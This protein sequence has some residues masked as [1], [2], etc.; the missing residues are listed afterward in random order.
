LRLYVQ[1][2]DGGEAR[3]VSP[4]GM[5]PESFSVS[6]DG[7]FVAAQGPDSKI[8]IYPLDGGA[9]HPLPGAVAGESP[10]VWSADGG[11]LYLFRSQEAPSQ[12]FRVDIATGRRD[13]CKTIAPADRSGLVQI[14]SIVMTPD[15]HSYAYSYERIL[16]E[17]EVVDGLR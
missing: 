7:R 2:L 12:V 6:P 4:E 10:I 3:A 16:T 15:A 14:D 17:L 8:A 13:L 11:S 1:N 5:P 9:A